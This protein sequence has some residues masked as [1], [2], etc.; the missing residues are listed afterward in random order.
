MEALNA[1]SRGTALNEQQ[2]ATRQQLDELRAESDALKVEERRARRQLAQMWKEH[3]AAMTAFK[4]IGDRQQAIE[5][6]I[7]RLLAKDSSLFVR[8]QKGRRNQDEQRNQAR[9]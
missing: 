3:E 6:E 4:A 9:R 1:I 8:A 2:A 7:K 5:R